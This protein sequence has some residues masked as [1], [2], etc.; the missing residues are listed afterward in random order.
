MYDL[1]TSHRAHP[2]YLNC[3]SMDIEKE[4]YHTE[5]VRKAKKLNRVMPPEIDSWRTVNYHQLRSYRTVTNTVRKLLTEKVGW[6][7]FV[8]FQSTE[9]LVGMAFVLFFRSDM[10]VSSFKLR[11]SVPLTR[12]TKHSSSC[13]G[14]S[15]Y[16]SVWDL[17]LDV[18]VRESL[19]LL[20]PGT[21]TFRFR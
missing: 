17:S 9:R 10:H 1:R 4:E 19:N 12:Q 8:P 3:R 18:I 16:V 6:G 2:T 15:L 5:V 20:T 13:A 11:G 21:A 14:M 7:K